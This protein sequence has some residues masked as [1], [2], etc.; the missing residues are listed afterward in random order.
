MTY[1]NSNTLARKS[2]SPRSKTITKPQRGTENFFVAAVFEFV[3]VIQDFN[4]VG[5][6]C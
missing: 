2:F 5:A 6:E 1:K 4:I 3:Y